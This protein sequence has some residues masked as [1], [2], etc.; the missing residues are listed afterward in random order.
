MLANR[1]LHQASVL[2]LFARDDLGSR[3]MHAH[4]PVNVMGGTAL[5]HLAVTSARC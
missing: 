2:C 3:S 4:A 1:G 5:A